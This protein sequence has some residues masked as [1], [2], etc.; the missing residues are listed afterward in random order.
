VP[1]LGVA[2]LRVEAREGRSVVAEQYSQAPL[3]LHRPLY[4]ED[5]L[6]PVVYIKSPS[7]GLLAG[8][9]H[10]LEIGVGEGSRLEMRTQA[11]ILVY[12]G[13]SEQK[14]SIRVA[15][16]S[17]LV[18]IP[19]PLILAKGAELKQRIRIDLAPD[20]RLCFRDS[21]SAGRIAMGECWQFERF[22]NLLEIFV[23]RLLVY[24]DRWVIEPGRRPLTHPAVC[25]EYTR[26]ASTYCFGPGVEPPA[27]AEPPTGT[28]SWLLEKPHGRIHKLAARDGI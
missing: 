1:N 25:G 15:R 26:F 3:Q 10:L 21:F 13:A 16:G 6:C 8:D 17:S 9:C 5:P 4:L 12:P 27:S 11:A 28:V 22:D 24:R 19:H 18:F 14:I 20:S 23:E 7:A 2:R